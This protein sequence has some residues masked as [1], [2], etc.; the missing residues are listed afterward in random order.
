MLL[1]HAERDPYKRF[2]ESK[3]PLNQIQ[4]M[5]PSKK[6]VDLAVRSRVVSSIDNFKLDRVYVARED[7]E[8]RKLVEDIVRE[9]VCHAQSS[10]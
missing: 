6:L 3:G 10:S 5:L 1:D 7:A 4:I 9:E 8:S 2:Q